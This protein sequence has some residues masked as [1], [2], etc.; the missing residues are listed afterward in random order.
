LEIFWLFSLN[1][2]HIVRLDKIRLFNAVNIE[3]GYKALAI[4]APR[5]VT[6]YEAEDRDPSR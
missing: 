4:H 2:R 1:F 5:E 6:T 3:M